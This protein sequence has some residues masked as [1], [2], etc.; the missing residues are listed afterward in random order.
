[1]SDYDENNRGVLFKN[2][3]K[4]NDRHPDYRGKINVDG[5][6]KEISAWIKTSKKGGKFMSIAVSDPYHGSK[7]AASKPAPQPASD[8]PFGDEI[9]F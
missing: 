2:H 6:E 1:M 8:D 9:P 7:K 4:E 3:R 5:V